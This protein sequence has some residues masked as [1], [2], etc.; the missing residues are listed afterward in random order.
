MVRKAGESAR[1]E[2]ETFR[3]ERTSPKRC[4]RRYPR[5]T[6][7]AS[8]RRQIP[9]AGVALGEVRHGAPVVSAE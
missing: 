2:L 5:P 3:R 4:T 6:E 8:Y 1:E 9:A 7:R